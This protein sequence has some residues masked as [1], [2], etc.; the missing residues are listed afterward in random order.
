M[1]SVV[2]RFNAHLFEDE[3]DQMFRLRHRVLV[4]GLKW[5]GVKSYDGKEIDQFDNEDAIYVLAIETGSEKVAACSRFIHSM[6]PNLSS[7]IYPDL[8]YDGVVPRDFDIYDATRLVVDSTLDT[9]RIYS[10]M[11]MAATP[12]LAFHLG[13]KDIT[14]VA[15]LN[16]FNYCSGFGMPL[17]Q[18]GDP[19]DDGLSKIIPMGYDLSGDPIGKVRSGLGYSGGPL[20]SRSDAGLLKAT[21]AY[22]LTTLPSFDS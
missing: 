7:E 14:G 19:V 8:F 16:V 18:H 20:I 2:T 12:E 4:E 9:D 3:L 5:E 15:Q 1:I 13:L 10:K 21:H 17:F 11:I 6:K 22:T